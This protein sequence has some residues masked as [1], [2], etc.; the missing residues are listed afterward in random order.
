M[1]FIRQRLANICLNLHDVAVEA[2]KRYAVAATHAH[3][4]HT[5][6]VVKLRFVLAVVNY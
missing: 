2:H 3:S 1:S 4:A 6:Q 5:P